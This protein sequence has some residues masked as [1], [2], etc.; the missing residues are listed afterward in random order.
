MRVTARL[1]ADRVE[2]AESL[3]AAAGAL[4]YELLVLDLGERNP[5]DSLDLELRPDPE[6]AR[7]RTT[8]I[9]SIWGGTIVIPNIPVERDL[10]PADR[11]R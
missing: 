5:G 6:A 8:S 11:N 7:S 10:E 2:F 9:N 1:G 3:T 4:S